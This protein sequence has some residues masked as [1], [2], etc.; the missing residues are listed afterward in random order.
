MKSDPE[1]GHQG[2]LK[3]GAL[4]FGVLAFYATLIA[5]LPPS[6]IAP[7]QDQ[8]ESDNQQAPAQNAGFAPIGQLEGQDNEDGASGDEIGE[9]MTFWS[10]LISTD[11]ANWALV[12]VALWA[13]ISALDTLNEMRL[14][15]GF[16]K[17]A[18]DEAKRQANAADEQTRIMGRQLT[19]TTR[20][21]MKP[22]WHQ[23]KWS[24]P[25]W[26]I[27]YGGDTEMTGSLALKNI[28][29]TTATIRHVRI[30][31]PAHWESRGQSH[32]FPEDVYTTHKFTLTWPHVRR[33]TMLVGEVAFHDGFRWRIQDLAY[34]IRQRD[35]PSKESL[36]VSRRPEGNNEHDAYEDER[37]EIVRV[38]A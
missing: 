27:L 18:A 1:N 2:G 3:F 34:K 31:H 13:A 23:L 30:T 36:G 7:Q 33:H 20:A 29:K 14:Q 17:G 15:S 12:F 24:T 8:N 5:V 16:S 28:G 6:Q 37:G 38:D 26:I 4:A 11:G 10:W 25:I 32:V 19:L 22:R 9:S 21:Y 35:Y